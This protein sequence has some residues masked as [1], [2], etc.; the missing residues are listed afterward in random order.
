MNALSKTKDNGSFVLKIGR[1]WCVRDPGVRACA[2]ELSQRQMSSVCNELVFWPYTLPAW[3]PNAAR[4]L[5]LGRARNNEFA[6]CKNKNQ[7]R[8][9]CLH[10]KWAPRSE[11]G[12]SLVLFFW[13]VELCSL[14]SS[15]GIPGH[16]GTTGKQGHERQRELAHSMVVKEG[17]VVHCHSGLSGS[18]SIDFLGSD[19]TYACNCALHEP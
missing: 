7:I 4:S 19:G 12:F 2:F 16:C 15:L 9:A 6:I 1:E 11:F 3:P 10:E 18:R 13:F 17:W 8:F 5:V 14:R